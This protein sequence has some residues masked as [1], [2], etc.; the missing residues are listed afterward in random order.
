MHA[1][2]RFCVNED[3]GLKASVWKGDIKG[4]TLLTAMTAPNLVQ[5]IMPLA[6]AAFEY[7]GTRE[8]PKS[9]CFVYGI[10]VRSGVIPHIPNSEQLRGYGLSMVPFYS[11]LSL[12]QQSLWLHLQQASLKIANTAQHYHPDACGGLEVSAPTFVWREFTT[13]SA[14]SKVIEADRETLSAE[15]TSI[16]SIVGMRLGVDTL[17]LLDGERGDH[18]EWRNNNGYP[19][20]LLA[21][22]L[23]C[24]TFMCENQE[25]LVTLT[26][27]DLLKAVW[28]Q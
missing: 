2:T 15:I 22:M 8:V 7:Q 11:V 17:M 25:D 12:A 19:V 21:V 28:A 16:V 23:R 5:A 18:A 24:L 3:P 26:L 27:D 6:I 4:L 9:V 10:G 1:I 20:S 13:G 14:W